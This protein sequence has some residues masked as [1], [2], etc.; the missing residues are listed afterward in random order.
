M[1]KGVYTNNTTCERISVLNLVNPQTN[2][3]R[4]R[5]SALSGGRGVSRSFNDEHQYDVL[6]L[7]MQNSFPN[8]TSYVREHMLAGLADEDKHKCR[9]ELPICEALLLALHVR[10]IDLFG[11]RP[12]LGSGREFARLCGQC[13]DFLVVW[14]AV[15]CLACLRRPRAQVRPCR[16]IY[17]VIFSALGHNHLERRISRTLGVP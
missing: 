17:P 7:Q 9:W 2:P 8:E 15:L 3:V 4:P 1:Q 12:D 14:T 6:L 5:A 13:G 10:G 11:V 16:V